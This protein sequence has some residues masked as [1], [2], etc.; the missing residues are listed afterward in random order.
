MGKGVE[1]NE[2]GQKMTQTNKDTHMKIK[3]RA[4]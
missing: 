3:I 2:Y 4:N 1:N